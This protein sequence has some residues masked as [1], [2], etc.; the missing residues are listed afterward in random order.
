MSHLSHLCPTPSPVVG[1]SETSSP[2]VVERCLTTHFAHPCPTR[3]H[4]K[5]DTHDHQ[6]LPRRHRPHRDRTP[7]RPLRRTT[8]RSARTR[9][10]RRSSDLRRPPTRP[11]PEVLPNCGR[12]A[13]RLIAPPTPHATIWSANGNCD[14]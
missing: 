14:T 1:Q 13:R 11:R 4:P 6:E 2:Y 7:N 3:P 12:S 10:S 5:R 9:P 8:T